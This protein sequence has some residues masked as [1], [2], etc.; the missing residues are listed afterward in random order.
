MGQQTKNTATELTKAMMSESPSLT[1]KYKEGDLDFSVVPMKKSDSPGNR[2]GAT[3]S[4]SSTSSFESMLDNTIEFLTFEENP[5]QVQVAAPKSKALVVKQETK[6]VQATET[7]SDATFQ[8]FEQLEANKANLS[9]ADLAYLNLIQKRLSRRPRPQLT[10]APAPAPV[11]SRDDEHRI[12]K[13]DDMHTS[14]TKAASSQ[15]DDNAS[16]TE[17]LIAN[18]TALLREATTSPGVADFVEQTEW[19]KDQAEFQ[20]NLQ[21]MMADAKVLN[22]NMDC[23]GDTTIE[24]VEEQDRSV[25]SELTWQNDGKR[26]TKVISDLRGL[27][28]SPLE[29]EIPEGSVG[30]TQVHFRSTWQQDG[31]EFLDTAN[32]HLT[33]ALVDLK[34]LDCRT[35][36]QSKEPAMS[37]VGGETASPRA[38]NDHVVINDHSCA[39]GLIDDWNHFEYQLPTDVPGCQLEV[40]DDTITVQLNQMDNVLQAAKAKAVGIGAA[41]NAT[42]DTVKPQ[43]QATKRSIRPRLFVVDERVAVE[44]DHAQE[45]VEIQSCVEPKPAE[46]PLPVEETRIRVQLKE[47]PTTIQEPKEDA[48]KV[49]KTVRRRR[50]RISGLHKNLL[51]SAKDRQS[52]DESGN[53]SGYVSFNPRTWGKSRRQGNES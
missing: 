13:Q 35:S 42:V 51:R 34:V 27:T 3:A 44:I 9:A 38:I 30:D 4:A 24:T 49:K 17:R 22:L 8:L 18:T 53:N 29:N 41:V 6:T 5:S 14:G 40:D 50:S 21:K 11:K 10:P 45:A 1:Y 7:V 19:Q 48:N 15:D 16:F 33:K 37:S 46:S 36:Y 32:Y 25:I 20:E 43:V 23:Q 47:M 39:C 12:F 26:F 31:T 2:S 28:C 52:D